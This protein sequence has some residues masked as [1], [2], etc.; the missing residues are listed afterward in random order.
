MRHQQLLAVWCAPGFGGEQRCGERPLPGGDCG[1]ADRPDSEK[2]V[3]AH[4]CADPLLQAAW[5]HPAQ[6]G[7]GGAGDRHRQKQAGGAPGPHQGPRHHGQGDQGPTNPNWRSLNQVELLRGLAGYTV[8]WYT[9]PMRIRLF[10]T[11]SF[12]TEG[13]RYEDAIL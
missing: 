1:A 11:N 2:A 5:P 8:L 7:P 9:R 13:V 6:R 10:L 4:P 12:L 3:A